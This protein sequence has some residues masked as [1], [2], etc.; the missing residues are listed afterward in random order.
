M[1]K[2]K[3]FSNNAPL[4]QDEINWSVFTQSVW[5]GFTT[6]VLLP[7]ISTYTIWAGGGDSPL[8]NPKRSWL[9]RTCE[10]VLA[11]VGNYLQ[12]IYCNKVGYIDM[13]RKG[14]FMYSCCH[15]VFPEAFCRYAFFNYYQTRTR[16]CSWTS[17]CRLDHISSIRLRV[18]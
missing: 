10:I 5:S 6:S 16:L 4:I 8:M 12:L 9:R 14:I 2:L 1:I 7:S 3:M 13:N 17:C 11:K 15:S 18:V